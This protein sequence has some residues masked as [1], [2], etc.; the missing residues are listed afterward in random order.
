V[1]FVFLDSER[2]HAVTPIKKPGRPSAT[3]VVNPVSAKEAEV[4][5]QQLCTHMSFFLASPFASAHPVPARLVFLTGPPTTASMD[6][7]IHVFT[8][9]DCML[10]NFILYTNVSIYFL[11]S[12][13]SLFLFDLFLFYLLILCT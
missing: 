2:S 9:H 12:I 11:S 10:F 4:I 7:L 3:K 1:F 13:V 8:R 6:N 5:V